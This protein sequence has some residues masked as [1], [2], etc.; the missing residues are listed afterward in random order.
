MGFSWIYDRKPWK[1]MDEI[2]WK[3]WY[4]IWYVKIPLFMT[5]SQTYLKVDYGNAWLVLLWQ[6]IYQV[7]I[8]Y[9]SVN[10][11]SIYTFVHS[12]YSLISIGIAR[13]GQVPHFIPVYWS[14]W[15]IKLLFC[16]L[17]LGNI[18]FYNQGFLGAILNKHS[19]PF[20]Q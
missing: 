20:T 1:I 11:S 12:R 5:Y 14:H 3:V 6:E 18:C 8:D 2:K 19:L 15:T 16:V 10:I 4:G 13:G 9:N 17:D 7:L